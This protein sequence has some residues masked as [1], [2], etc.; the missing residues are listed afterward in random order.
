M[1]YIFWNQEMTPEI[2]ETRWKSVVDDFGLHDM[3]W[4]N[5]LYELKEMWVPCYFMDLPMNGLMRTSSLSE[6]ENAFFK[7]CKNKQSTLV[8][9]FSRFDAAMEKQRHNNR[10]LEYEMENK[11][12]NCLT[13]KKIELH[14]RDVYTPSLFLLV[15]EEIERASLSCAQTSCVTDGDKQLCI[16]QEKFPPPR[17]KW[18]YKVILFL[19]ITCLFFPI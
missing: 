8:D 12:I 10:L 13:P 4:F 14:A 5:D 16:V 7:R 3:R 19:N 15:Q 18:N 9:F 6:S 1:N 11:A 2:F 17:P